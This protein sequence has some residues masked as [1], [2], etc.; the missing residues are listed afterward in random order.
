MQKLERQ[1]AV[2]RP[3]LAAAEMEVQQRMGLITNAKER[4][5]RWG[6][7]LHELSGG[8]GRC[9]RGCQGEV[10]DMGEGLHA[11]RGEEEEGLYVLRGSILV[12][13]LHPKFHLL[14]TLW[15]PFI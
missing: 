1:L 10:S 6:E 4:L 12:L 14:S 7:G 9:S 11:G 5:V 8:K 15:P 2:L 3:R 13:I